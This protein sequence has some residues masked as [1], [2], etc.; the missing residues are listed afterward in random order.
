MCVYNA[1]AEKRW[2]ARYTVG[3]ATTWQGGGYTSRNGRAG[4]TE[5][6]GERRGWAGGGEGRREWR[7]GGGGR[8]QSGGERAERELTPLPRHQIASFSPLSPSRG[9]VSAAA[10]P[11]PPPPPGRRKETCRGWRVGG[12][13]GERGGKGVYNWRR[14][15]ARRRAPCE[16]RRRRR[17]RKVEGPVEKREAIAKKGRKKRRSGRRERRRRDLLPPGFLL[18]RAPPSRTRAYRKRILLHLVPWAPLFLSRRPLFSLFAFYFLF[19]AP[20]RA[21]ARF[22]LLSR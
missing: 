12:R 18:T 17:R 11:L 21:H 9:S 2:M 20:S 5:G 16:E 15:Y 10:S 19:S 13:S 8:E 7:E 3:M 22:H 14:A 4:A 1:R 6:S